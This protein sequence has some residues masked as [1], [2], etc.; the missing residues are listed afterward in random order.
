MSLVAQKCTA[1]SFTGVFFYEHRLS[2]RIAELHT[3]TVHLICSET[4][5]E[6]ILM[7]NFAGLADSPLDRLD[8]LSRTILYGVCKTVIP[9]R[10]ED[11]WKMVMQL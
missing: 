8:D 10:S 2:S 5:S 9:V 11:G 3:V 1:V 4:S 6:H 7:V